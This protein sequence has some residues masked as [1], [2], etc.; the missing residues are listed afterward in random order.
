MRVA[1]RLGVGVGV[2]LFV[3]QELAE[4]VGEVGQHFSG[5]RGAK[6][7]RVGQAVVFGNAVVGQARRQVEHVARFQGPLFALLEFGKDAQVG[8]LQQRAVAAAHLADLPVALAVALQQEHVVVVEVRANAAARR[9]KADHHIVDA[10]AW[11]EAEVLQQLADFRHE[12]VDRLHQQGPVALGQGAEGIFFE[13]AAAQFPWAFAVLDDQAR[14]DFFFQGQAGQ[15]VGVDRAFEI[16]EGLAH[17]QR[18]LLPVV[19]HEFA[20]SEAAQQLQWSI[21]IHV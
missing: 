18:F 17:Q 8:V 19:A 11:Q 9:C 6:A 12:L 2:A 20:G 5:A 15:F 4:E 3:G 13:R 16:S 14:F 10:P 21:R 7:H 1:D